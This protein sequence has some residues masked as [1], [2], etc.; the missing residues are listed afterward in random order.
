MFDIGFSEL[1]VIG[2]VALVVLGPERLPKAARTAGHLLGRARRYI[3][4]VKA[5]VSRELELDELRR[6]RTE[7]HD[8][9]QQVES[10]IHREINE[11]EQQIHGVIDIVRQDSDVDSAVEAS[12]LDHDLE[13]LPSV[14]P[15]P[16]PP[17]V[18]KA[19]KLRALRRLPHPI[20]PIL[21]KEPHHE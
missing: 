14:L 7:V 17:A 20:P 9:V 19:A 1:A 12:F 13:V 21:T 5:D 3:D 15:H 10:S 6:M 16:A 4:Q 8:A 2:V 11:A 18:F